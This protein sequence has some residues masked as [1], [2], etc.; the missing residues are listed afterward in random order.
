MVKRESIETDSYKSDFTTSTM[1]PPGTR[2]ECSTKRG[3]AT[4]HEVVIREKS[5]LEVVN[6]DKF[7]DFVAESGSHKHIGILSCNPP[8]LH[9]K[10]LVH[11]VH[12]V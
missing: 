10:T 1:F 3:M 8:V 7:A 6:P 9:G 11:L 5:G 12:V 2:F 4:C